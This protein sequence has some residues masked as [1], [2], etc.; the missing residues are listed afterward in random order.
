MCNLRTCC[1]TNVPSIYL[2]KPVEIQAPPFVETERTLFVAGLNLRD[3]ESQHCMFGS[4]RMIR[5][6]LV[7]DKNS[8]Q[9]STNNVSKIS[10]PFGCR[11]PISDL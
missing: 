8:T 5:F 7:S 1:T 9:L 3:H 6:D 10:D 2:S 4:R 11:V